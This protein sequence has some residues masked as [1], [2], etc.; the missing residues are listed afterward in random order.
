[1]IRSVLPLLLIP[2]LIYGG[3]VFM[4]WS[5]QDRLVYLPTREISADPASAGMPFEDV[6]LQTAD[7][8]TLHGWFVPADP[9]QPVIL[10]LHGNAGNISHRLDTL[11]IFHRLN[12]NVLLIDYRGYGQSTGKPTEEGTYLDAAAAWNYLVDVR[13]FDPQAILIFG[14]SLGG[15]IAGWLASQKSSGALVLESTFTSIADLGAESYR[16]LP[17]RSLT[18]IH[19]DTRSVLPTITTPVLVLHSKDDDIIAFHHGEALFEA[20]NNP[21]EFVPLVGDH[22]SGFLNSGEI[23]IEAW[24]RALQR[25][26][27]GDNR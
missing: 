25:V 6:S 24:Q 19:Y 26:I 23:Y 20:A 3:I 16:W 11:E 10:F 17:V 2:L 12:A 4:M 21:V 18:R 9:S 27:K 15:A 7:G 1:M 22:N 8:E 14:R 5:M 13:G